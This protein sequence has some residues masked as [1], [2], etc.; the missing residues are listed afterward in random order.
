LWGIGK[1]FKTAFDDGFGV[2]EI[3][4]FFAQTL[5]GF[6]TGE[7]GVFASI[8]AFDACNGFTVA[9]TL[10]QSASSTVSSRRAIARFKGQAAQPTL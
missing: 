6:L 1:G 4:V 9:I 3:L 10:P 8:S 5:L 2:T 7:R